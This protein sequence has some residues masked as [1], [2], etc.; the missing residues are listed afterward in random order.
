M[1]VCVVHLLRSARAEQRVMSL[2]SFDALRIQTADALH[3]I[4]RSPGPLTN[5]V[6]LTQG[7]SR[8]A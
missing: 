6:E 3:G 5:A 2:E 4:G 8:Q 1:D 7:R